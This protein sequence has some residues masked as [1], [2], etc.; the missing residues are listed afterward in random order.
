MRDTVGMDRV[1]EPPPARRRIVLWT[2][3]GLALVVAL[4]AARPLIARWGSADRSIERSRLRLATVKRG[5]LVHDVAVQGRVV[6]ASRPTLFSPAAGIVDLRVKEGEAVA[7]DQVLAVVES[8]DLDSRL[9]QEKAT[10]EALRSE[11]SRLELS[12]RQ[13]NLANEQQEALLGV[14]RDAAAREAQRSEAL[15]AQGLLND[16]ELERARDA[17]R[18]ASLELEQS[19]RSKGLAREMLAF[20]VAD[21]RH[22]LEGQRL[23]VEEAA[24]RVAQLTIRSPFT[25][26]VA[27]LEAEDRDAVVAGQAL[28]GVVDLGELEVAVNIPEAYA[29][30]ATP[31]VAAAVLVDGANVAGRLTRVAPEVQDSQVEG[32]VAFTHGLPPGL[33]QNQ[34]LSVRL[35]LDQRHD[36]L[37]V[38][39]GPFLESGG[40]K[41]I[42]VVS[43]GVARRRPIEVGAVS[44]TEVEVAHGLEEGEQVV[45]SDLGTLEGSSTVLIRD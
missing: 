11:V 42:Y 15:A 37:K 7:A 36:V 29:D 30:D 20:Q 4:V 13:Q 28:L 35:I 41:A 27:T 19:S 40:G 6:A 43:D 1:L 3:A 39:R 25:G 32:R 8:P 24:R 14:R 23:A 18:V 5:D 22:R 2:A 31:G 21:A 33:R 44:V 17:L 10:W 38:P 9:E 16:I 26:L 45:L 34:R 12:E